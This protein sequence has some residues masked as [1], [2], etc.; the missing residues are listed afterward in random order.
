MFDIL[1][2][3]ILLSFA[4]RQVIRMPFHG[5]NEGNMVRVCETNGQVMHRRLEVFPY[6]I[7]AQD[8]RHAQDLA[9]AAALSYMEVE[10]ENTSTLCTTISYTDRHGT[11]CVECSNSVVEGEN[12]KLMCVNPNCCNHDE[13][14]CPTWVKELYSV[15]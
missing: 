12:G 11:W 10:W 2:Q 6:P 15:A 8:K 4:A 13:V 5:A 1:A 3:P 9:L 7:G 14:N